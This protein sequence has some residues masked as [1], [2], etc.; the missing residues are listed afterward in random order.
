MSG[1]PV[2]PANALA[3]LVG[4]SLHT[5]L[6]APADERWAVNRILEVLRLDD[7]GGYAG[8]HLDPP[9]ATAD[10]AVAAAL[11][12]GLATGLIEDTAGQ[13]DLLDAALMGALMARPSTVTQEFWRRYDVDPRRATDYFYRLSEDS[14]YIHAARTARNPTWVHPSRYGELDMTINLA[15]PEKDPRDIIAAGKAVASGYPRCLLCP[16]NEGYAGRIDHPGRQNLR[17]IELELSSRPWFFQYSPYVYYNEHCIVL[18]AAHEPMRLTRDTFTRLLEFVG[19]F[20]EYFIGSNADLPIVG[21]SILSHDHFQGGRYEFPIERAARLAQFQAPLGMRAEVL[22]WP[23]SVLRI[24]GPDPILLG[25]LGF[26][27]LQAWRSQDVPET[28]VQA[29]SGETPHNTV[30]PI[31][32]RS[33]RD[34]QLDVVL[35][36]N[37]TSD[38]HPDGIFHPHAEI[39]PVKKENIGLIEVMGLAV[40]PARLATDIPRLA[41]ALAAQMDLPADLAAHGPMLAEIAANYEDAELAVRAAVGD[42]FTRG[43]EHCGVLG[44]PTESSPYWE[45]FLTPLGFVRD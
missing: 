36:N 15:K 42:Y 27:V 44:D 16:E 18:S 40:L 24:T 32:R 33:G 1:V 26:E 22:D 2:D 8:P 19:Q 9:P 5:G 39:H 29:Y 28:G 7:V 11:E 3:D 10:D 6:V 43:L 34:Y 23:L 17:L 35:R 20:N 37:R 25:D 30:T 38:A 41:A 14:N 13:R 12:V 21:G 45:R 4:Y 31:A